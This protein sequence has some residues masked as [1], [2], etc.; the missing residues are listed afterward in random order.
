MS[1]RFSDAYVDR[2]FEQRDL[3]GL[4]HLISVPG[5]DRDLPCELWLFCRMLEWMG[6]TRSGVWQYYEGV[7]QETFQKI[8][9]SLDKYGFA[10]LAE[11]YR[12]G[13]EAW[14]GSERA[15]SL[16]K[17]IDTHEVQ[18]EEWLLD[19]AIRARDSLKEGR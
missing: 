7:S 11:K 19:L 2:L 13:K 6:S 5:R 14:D 12:H 9:G 15:A 1:V 18:I 8:S 17:W 4:H 3:P 10:E 16:D